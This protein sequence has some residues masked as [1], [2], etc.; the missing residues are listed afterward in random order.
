MGLEINA[1]LPGDVYASY[2]KAV[3]RALRIPERAV[4]RFQEAYKREE[5]R[6]RSAERGDPD[7]PR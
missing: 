1:S 2:L 6:D 7:R 4:D 5:E 3:N